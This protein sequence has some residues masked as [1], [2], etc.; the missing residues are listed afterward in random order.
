[1]TK[2]NNASWSGP[3]ASSMTNRVPMMALNGVNTF[4]RTISDIER[5]VFAGTSFTSPAA[6]RCATWADVSP[7][8]GSATAVPGCVMRPIRPEPDV[9]RKSENLS[10]A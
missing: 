10:G 7:E 2:P 6:T 8:S 1:M 3:T 9:G 4:E 5:D